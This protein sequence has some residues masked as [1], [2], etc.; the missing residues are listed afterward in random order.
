MASER[1]ALLGQLR[2]VLKDESSGREELSC[3]RGRG[4]SCAVTWRYFL[5][6]VSWSSR[7]WDVGL[8]LLLC[9]GLRGFLGLG[10]RSRGFWG[11]RRR[12]S[13]ARERGRLVLGAIPFGCGLGRWLA[14]AVAASGCTTRRLAA[15]NQGGTLI[16]VGGGV[17]GDDDGCLLLSN[18][19]ARLLRD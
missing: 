7:S 1:E 4:V 9:S 13:W 10:R 12:G 19:G 14:I 2:Q 8:R 6:D 16:A 11:T 18:Q 5:L 17:A 3:R 15:G